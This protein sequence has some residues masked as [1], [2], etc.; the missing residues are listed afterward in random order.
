MTRIRN[1]SDLDLHAEQVDFHVLMK[2]REESTSVLCRHVSYG[3]V[4][5]E[6]KETAGA[7]FHGDQEKHTQGTPPRFFI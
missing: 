7:T 4:H 1:P 2:H 5:E 6:Q 3:A